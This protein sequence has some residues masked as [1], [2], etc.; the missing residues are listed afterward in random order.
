MSK[1]KPYHQFERSDWDAV[2]SPL[3]RIG[4]Y[5]HYQMLKTL[6]LAL[7]RADLRLSEVG[8]ILDVGCGQ[9]AWLNRIADIRG[10][11]HGL[12]GVDISSERLEVAKRMNPGIAYSRGDMRDLAFPDE[13]FDLVTAFASLMFLP[14]EKGFARAL[15]EMS[16]VLR[17]GGHLFLLEPSRV[18][19]TQD[20]RG[21]GMKDLQTAI[22]G[23][24]IKLEFTVP[25][26]RRLGGYSTAS[27]IRKLPEWVCFLIDYCS[28]LPAANCLYVLKVK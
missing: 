3:N 24:R 23:G 7:K 9:G 6:S 14:D 16:R 15:T 27:L 18:G 13:S 10:S 8:T 26:F 28:F 4:R 5:Q 17:T 20:T 25:F 21:T 19:H 1:S 11:A 12:H 2:Y 22:A